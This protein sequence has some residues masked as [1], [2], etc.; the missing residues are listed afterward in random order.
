MKYF[1]YDEQRNGTVYHEFYK[2]KWDGRTF[3]KKDSIS[4]GDDILYVHYGFAEAIMEV[5]P[6]Y[7]AFGETEI[8]YLEWKKI[9]KAVKNKSI[10]VQEI[11]NEADLW[12]NSKKV[13]QEYKCFT[14][15]GI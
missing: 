2:G 6:D 9:G 11:Y 5:V 3:W 7:D 10:E 4:L 12:L 13:F 15:L 14:I 1:V 8:S